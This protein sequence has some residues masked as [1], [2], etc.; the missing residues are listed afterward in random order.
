[1]D[2]TR[3]QNFRL[4]RENVSDP[5]PDLARMAKVLRE[6]RL[7]YHL[8]LTDVAKLLN[9]SYQ[10]YQNYERGKTLPTLPNFIRLADLYGLSLDALIGRKE[11]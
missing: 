10:S 3:D 11:L 7:S 5:E 2:E 9:I 1:M 6:Q 8:L 4:L